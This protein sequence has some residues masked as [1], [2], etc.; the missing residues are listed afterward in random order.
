M[1]PATFRLAS[2]SVGDHSRTVTGFVH[3]GWGIHEGR[4]GWRVTHLPSGVAARIDIPDQDHAKS[5]VE[6]LWR[7]GVR[8][9]Y[10]ADLLRHKHQHEFARA[11]VLLNW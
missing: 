10:S 8:G 3:L 6:D 2:T 5:Y 7:L 9:Y 4:W 11:D 1:T